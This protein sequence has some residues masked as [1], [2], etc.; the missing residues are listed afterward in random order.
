MSLCVC[1]A[2]LILGLDN[3][4]ES[5]PNS[6]AY[7]MLRTV[8]HR[9][10]GTSFLAAVLTVN[11]YTMEMSCAAVTAIEITGRCFVISFS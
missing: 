10:R 2:I 3:Q 4:N 7:S 6:I 8:C 11:N 9:K 5:N 1:S